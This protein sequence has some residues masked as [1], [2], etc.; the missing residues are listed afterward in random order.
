MRS[1]G[2]SFGS[3]SVSMRHRNVQTVKELNDCYIYC[4]V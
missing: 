3:I 2:Y 1:G 4:R